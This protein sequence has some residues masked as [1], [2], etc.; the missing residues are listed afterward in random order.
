MS[1][2]IAACSGNAEATPTVTVAPTAEPTQAIHTPTQQP[3][4]MPTVAPAVPTP[5]PTTVPT[6]APTWTPTVTPV[7]PTPTS[8]PP[9][10]TPTE[11]PYPAEFSFEDRFENGVDGWVVG[12]ADLPV[13]WNNEIY[14]LDSE[15]RQMPDGLDGSGIYVQGHNRSDDLFMYLSKEVSGLKPNTSYEVSIALDLATNV[16]GGMMGIGGSPGDSVYVKAGASSN[17]PTVSEDNIG[18][19]RLNVDKGNQS[20]SGSEMTVIGNVTNFSV[21]N[22]EFKIK[23]LENTGRTVTVSSDE[24][25]RIW[26]LVGTDSGFEG[27]SAFYYSAIRYQLTVTE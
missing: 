11:I 27:L 12:F 26:V 9:T 21:L 1:L 6:I 19:L 18:H 15:F 25:G 5:T 14:E 20:T 17:E 4:V 16:P 8:V 22:D 23:T 3:T 10:P 7:P 24:E 13:D 2:A